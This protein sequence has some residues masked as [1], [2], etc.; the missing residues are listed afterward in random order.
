LALH[1][2]SAEWRAGRSGYGHLGTFLPRP[3]AF[4]TT[5][6]WFLFAFRG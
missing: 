4:F 2:D 3:I 1:A 6:R 5:E